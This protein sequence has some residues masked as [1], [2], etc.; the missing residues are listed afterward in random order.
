MR[1]Q[2]EEL[3]PRKRLQV[4]ID[5]N[6]EFAK[7]PAIKKAREASIRKRPDAAPLTTKARHP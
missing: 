5:G 4:I 2:N 3:R 7:V 6:T 1:L